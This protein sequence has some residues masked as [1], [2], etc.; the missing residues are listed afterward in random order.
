M[1]FEKEYQDACT[2]NTDI[3]EHLPWIAEFSAECKHGT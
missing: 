2:R 3:H 1:D